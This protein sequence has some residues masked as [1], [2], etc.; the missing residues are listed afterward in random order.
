MTEP[1]KK[2]KRSA[3]DDQDFTELISDIFNEKKT[4]NFAALKLPKL[5]P[6]TDDGVTFSD[7][8]DDDGKSTGHCKCDSVRCQTQMR[9]KNINFIW[10]CSVGGDSYKLQKFRRHQEVWHAAKQTPSLTENTMAKYCVTRKL[11]KQFV[12]KMRLAQVKVITQQK[13]PLNCFEKDPMRDLI[14]EVFA[15]FG[16]NTDEVSQILFSARSLKKTAYEQSDIIR[17]YIK[18]NST[19]LI[20]SCQMSIALDHKTLALTG[21]YVSSALG[22]SLM[23][24]HNKVRHNYLLTFQGVQ[25]KTDVKTVSVARQILE[26]LFFNQ[27]KYIIEHLIFNYLESIP[28]HLRNTVC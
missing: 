8:L 1:S 14:A 23:I 22:I 11:P 4:G 17:Q 20:K 10:K 15:Y 24:N 5:K 19:K 9:Q 25:D 26:V 18:L 6:F 27:F 2:R 12:Q 3:A 16:R 13:L 21:E 7:L 28:L